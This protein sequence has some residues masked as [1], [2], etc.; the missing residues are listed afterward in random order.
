MKKCNRCKKVKSLSDFKENQ[1]KCNCCYD[2]Q[3][4]YYQVNKE[5][6]REKGRKYYRDN[7]TKLRE[8]WSRYYKANYEKVRNTDL[9]RIF[10][11]TFEEYKKKLIDQN[12]KC[13]ICGESGNGRSLCNNNTTS[14]HVDHCH[15]TKKVR[16]LLCNRCNI[17]LGMMRDDMQILSKAI[18]YLLR[19][20]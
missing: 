13:A 18:E 2:Y 12:G 10:G 17:A 19:H 16:G 3:M 1:N 15:K 7:H 11:I 8:K 6:I 4:N 5:K 20:N 9:K 14:L